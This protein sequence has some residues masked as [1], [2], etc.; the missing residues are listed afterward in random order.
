MM[1]PGMKPEPYFSNHNQISNKIHSVFKQSISIIF[2]SLSEFLLSLDLVLSSKSAWSSVPSSALL[3]RFHKNLFRNK[4]P[5]YFHPFRNSSGTVEQYINLKI[6]L[7]KR[8]VYTYKEF[9]HQHVA[10]YINPVNLAFSLFR[11]NFSFLN[12]IL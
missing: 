3:E 10:I 9:S 12:L 1:Q 5:Q 8:T 6:Y 7:V 4:L 11:C 2:T